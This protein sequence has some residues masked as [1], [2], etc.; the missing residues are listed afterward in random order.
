VNH[1]R[2]P[3][4]DHLPDWERRDNQVKKGDRVECIYSIDYWTQR[5]CLTWKLFPRLAARKHWNVAVPSWSC[6]KAVYK[7]VWHIPLLS[8]QWIN[9]W[10]WAGELSETCRVLC[11]NKFVKLVHLVGFII[12]KSPCV[13]PWRRS[14]C[15]RY[16]FHTRLCCRLVVEGRVFLYTRCTGC[17]SGDLAAKSDLHVITSLSFKYRFSAEVLGTITSRSEVSACVMLLKWW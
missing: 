12:K 7:R 14:T 10:W 5:G 15:L 3:K 2:F 4:D 9:S 13:I 6:S 1:T 11:Q 8:V 16:S 17:R